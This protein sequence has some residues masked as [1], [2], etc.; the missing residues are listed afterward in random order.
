MESSVE[1]GMELRDSSLGPAKAG[2]VVKARRRKKLSIGRR[3]KMKIKEGDMGY[4]MRCKG[5]LRR[6]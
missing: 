6:C 2:R 1:E 3:L 4:G 5:A